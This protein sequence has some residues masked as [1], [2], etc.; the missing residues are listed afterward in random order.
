MTSYIILL[1]IGAA[2][3]L[4]AWNIRRLSRAGLARILVFV[5]LAANGIAAL[6]AGA[7]FLMETPVLAQEGQNTQQTGPQAGQPAATGGGWSGLAAAIAAGLGA[8]GAGIAVAG[9][10]A[11]AIGAV[12]QNPETFGRSL[13]FVGL[14]EGIAIYGLIIAF[15]ILMGF[16]G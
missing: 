10:G 13:V 5:L 3:A 4:A 7:F 12:T 2:A 6:S 8:I 1:F 14:A 16:G 11:A 9:T 15:M